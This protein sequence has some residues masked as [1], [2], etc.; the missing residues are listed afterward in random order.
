MTRSVSFA[1]AVAL[2]V[3]LTTTLAAATTPVADAARAGDRG[4]VRKALAAGAGVDVPHADGKTALHWAAMHRE[5][6]LVSILVAA[7]ANVG[8]RTRLGG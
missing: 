5:L 8:L 4:A 2:A 6:E 3:A 1:S 7:G